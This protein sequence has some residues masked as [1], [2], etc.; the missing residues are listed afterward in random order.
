MTS[1][2]FLFTLA[3]LAVFS[4][5]IQPAQAQSTARV[6]FLVITDNTD[7][8]IG[9]VVSFDPGLGIPVIRIEDPEENIPVFL[10]VRN[11]TH[12]LGVM[13]TTFFEDPGCLGT[14][15]H[16]STFSVNELGLADL[17]GF[18]HSVAL[19]GS[20]GQ[21]LF[22]SDISQA[23]VSTGIQSTY[24][25]NNGCQDGGNTLTLRP[26]VAVMDLDTAFPSPYKFR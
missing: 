3:A 25:F 7:I 5:A 2:T 11:S 9:P 16:D 19:P 22:R 21:W 1:K 10:Q 12:M 17:T 4:I 18:I 8:P 6:P 24:T 13:A 15:Y 26:A 20:G 14:A 23:G